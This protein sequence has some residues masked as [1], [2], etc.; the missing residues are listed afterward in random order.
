MAITDYAL[1]HVLLQNW[2]S[3]SAEITK[4]QEKKSLT[5][6]FLFPKIDLFLPLKNWLNNIEINDPHLAHRLCKLI[7]TQCPFHRDLKVF[8]YKIL[9][10]PPLCK[11]NPVYDELMFLRFKAI[12]YLAEECGE[13]VSNYC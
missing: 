12:S 1:S 4:K 13:D 6:H 3:D 5:Q 2:T 10:I 11:L 8:G 9:T 7:P